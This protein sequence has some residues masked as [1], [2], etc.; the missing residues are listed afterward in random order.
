MTRKLIEKRVLEASRNAISAKKPTLLER[1]LN[2]R[3]LPFLID[4]KQLSK[5]IGFS[6]SALRKM[7]SE[8]KSSGRST[9]P[10]HVRIG[11]RVR[12]R[13]DVV[14]EWLHSLNMREGQ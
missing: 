9:L 8:G 1:I 5:L 12:Y 7:R 10:Q 3:N 11:G 14:I 2:D 4:D 13:L 6:P